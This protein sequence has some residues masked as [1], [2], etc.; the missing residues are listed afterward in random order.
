MDKQGI[1][2]RFRENISIN[3]KVYERWETIMKKALLF[4]SLVALSLALSGCGGGSG[5][6]ASNQKEATPLSTQEYSQMYTDPTKFKGRKVDFYLKVFR[7]PEKDEKGTYIQAWA[8]P[9]SSNGNTLI[10][11]ADPNFQVKDGDYIHVVGVVRDKFTGKNAFGA[12]V[13]APIIDAELVEKTD[14]I[15]AVAPALKTISVGQEQNQKG[16]KV[17]VE[18]IE[19]AKEETRVYV[20]VKNESK[21][22]INFYNHAT[23]LVQGSTQLEPEMNFEGDYKQIQSD[24]LPGVSS[25]GIIVFKAIDPKAGDI[26]LITDGSSDNFNMQIK[27]FEFNVK[28]Q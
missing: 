6:T 25:D 13:S 11:Y 27:P 7:E 26:K 8:D 19:F 12:E 4:S 14:Y 21:D 28:L 18:K 15:T 20:T 22:K 9:K 23:K 5:T 17:K 10:A 1:I 16:Y 3:V 2:L 24:I